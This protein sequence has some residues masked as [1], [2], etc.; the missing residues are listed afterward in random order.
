MKRVVCRAV[1]ASACARSRCR[2]ASLRANQAV[3][4]SVEVIDHADGRGRQH[5]GQPLAAAMGLALLQRVEADA[6][7]A[8]Q[9]FQAR[10][11]AAILVRA[12]VGRDGLAACRSVSWPSAPSL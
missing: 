12:H 5:H 1:S 4:A 2:S 8:G 7:H 10:V 11:L 6:E 3:T 9:Q